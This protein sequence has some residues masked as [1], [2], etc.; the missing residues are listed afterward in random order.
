MI[1]ELTIQ[2]IG[3]RGLEGDDIVTVDFGN[4]DLAGVMV[5]GGPGDDTI[6]A[7]TLQHTATFFG[8]AG[9]DILTG[10]PNNDT[11][12]GD[13]GDDVLNGNG[14]NDWLYGDAGNDQLLGA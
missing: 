1:Q 7:T 10:G 6:S 14:G 3:I 9:N 8:G 2:N 5:D 13:A 4:L 11:L 12:H